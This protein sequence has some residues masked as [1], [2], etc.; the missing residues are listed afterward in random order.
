MNAATQNV[1]GG[2][3]G[4]PC[5]NP[6]P[7]SRSGQAAAVAMDAPTD[8]R[9]ARLT[10]AP[11]YNALIDKVFAPRTP[12]QRFASGRRVILLIAAM[13]IMGIVD[14]MLTL[15]YMRSTGM[16]E[17]NPIARTIATMG[18]GEHLIAFKLITM[19]VSGFALY[20][21]RHSRRGECAA[22]AC[23]GLLVVL[24]FHWANYAREATLMTNELFILAEYGEELDSSTAWVR[25]ASQ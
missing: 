13:S 9:L 21:G 11:S 18:A 3:R 22:W 20:L 6:P 8:D 19:F 10:I 7:D 25:L 5:V 17:A 1:M 23:A 24:M 15:T 2:G 12:E 16:Y 4:G 14:L